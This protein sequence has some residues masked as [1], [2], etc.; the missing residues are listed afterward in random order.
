MMRKGHVRIL[1]AGCAAAL[2]A[3][4]GATTALAATT[5]TIKPGGSTSA[6]S[7]NAIFIR[8]WRPRCSLPFDYLLQ[9]FA[10]RNRVLLPSIIRSY[11]PRGSTIAYWACRWTGRDR[12][13]CA[14][15][16]RLGGLIV[17]R[18]FAPVTCRTGADPHHWR[19][20]LRHLRPLVGHQPLTPAARA[21][22]AGCHQLLRALSEALSW[23]ITAT[24][25]IAHP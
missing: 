8:V 9:V 7:G 19:D 16:A 13:S 5:W 4:L 2:A 21:W 14:W 17:V 25:T 24:W 11:Y 20:R 18:A 1:L 22:P 15:Q 23:S 3:A 6:K 10:I 12:S